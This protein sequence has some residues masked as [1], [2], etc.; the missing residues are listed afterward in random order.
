MNLDD[1]LLA[2][3]DKIRYVENIIKD[4][5]VGN[6]VGGREGNLDKRQRTMHLM[7]LRRSLQEEESYFNN[8]AMFED[9][10]KPEEKTSVMPKVA[11]MPKRLFYP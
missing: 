6:S 5:A 4:A 11:Q 2:D 9:P 3:I 7:N 10:D 1:Y 8:E